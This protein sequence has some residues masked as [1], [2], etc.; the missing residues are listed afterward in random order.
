MVILLTFRAWFYLRSTPRPSCQWECERTEPIEK[1]RAM[2]PVVLSWF[3]L[4]TSR[5]ASR[6]GPPAC[7]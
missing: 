2:A 5:R 3:I 4:I 1:L 7:R 6:R